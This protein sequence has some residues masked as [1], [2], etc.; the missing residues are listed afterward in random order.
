MIA[1]HLDQVTVTYVNDPIFSGLS[2]EIHDDR[3]VGLIGPNGSG[4]S[5]LMKL[6]A[7]EL[8][9]ESGFTN[10]K[11][12]LTIGYLRQEPRLNPENTLWEEAMGASVKLAE[13]NA[14]LSQIEKKLAD[15]A[16]YG[17]EKKLA[18]TLDQQTK[19]LDQF[20]ALGGQ[21]YESWVR[22]TLLSL[23]FPK[24]ILPCLLPF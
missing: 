10:A 18:R 1:V 20:T 16:V 22:S 8:T 4:K 13:V 2:W 23:G 24:R 11:S 7:G 15:P 17:D 19:L 12:G 21:N 9:S 5:T 3:V 6:I 14:A